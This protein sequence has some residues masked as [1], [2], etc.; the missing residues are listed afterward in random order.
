MIVADTNVW[1]RAFLNDDVSEAQKA[2]KALADA[3][4]KGGVF[5]PLIVLAEL[6]WVL[7]THWTRER[8]LNTLES[9]LHTRGVAVESPA[10]TRQALHES[11]AGRGGFADQLIAQVGF[12]NGANAIITFDGKFARTAKVRR[13]K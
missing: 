5:V 1:A 10:L 11:R 4:S 3:R 12:A 9:L 8:V 6:A 13:L 7:R 2:R